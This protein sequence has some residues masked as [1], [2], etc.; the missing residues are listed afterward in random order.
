M[1]CYMCKTKTG[2]FQRLEKARIN[3]IRIAQPEFKDDSYLCLKCF[4]QFEKIYQYKKATNSSQRSSTSITNGSIKS[5]SSKTNSSKNS[6]R[7][8][9]TAIQTSDGNNNANNNSSSNVIQF[10]SRSLTSNDTIDKIVQMEPDYLS[11]RDSIRKTTKNPEL[12][13]ARRQA[14]AA[15]RRVLERQEEENNSPPVESG[16]DIVIPFDSRSVEDSIDSIDRIVQM[17]EDTLQSVVRGG[18]VKTHQEEEKTKT[19]PTPARKRRLEIVDEEDDA[20]SQED[21]EEIQLSPTNLAHVR[22]I[23]RRRKEPV[24]QQFDDIM[25]IYIARTSGG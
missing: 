11:L 3:F 18:P 13:M 4:K 19:T 25:D 15:V 21:I 1:P 20:N 2:P 10:D 23:V 12:I 14:E 17:A 7:T 24:V 22:P 8:N 16:S 5:V 6:T 9:V